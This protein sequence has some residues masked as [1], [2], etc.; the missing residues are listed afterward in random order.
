M[1]SAMVAPASSL[2]LQ[3]NAQTH[4]RVPLIINNI[5][6]HDNSDKNYYTLADSAEAQRLMQEEIHCEAAWAQKSFMGSVALIEENACLAT[7]QALQ[8][9]IPHTHREGAHAAVINRPFG[10]VLGIAP[11]NSP[12]ILAFRAVIAPL[13]AGNTVILKGSEL[14]PKTRF[15]VAN[16]FVEAGFPPGVVNFLLHRPQDAASVV[17]SLINNPAV[18]KINFTGSTKVGR[19]IAKAAGE[20]IKPVLLELGGKNCVLVLEDTDVQRAAEGVLEG[21][22][23]NLRRDPTISA[24]RL[25]IERQSQLFDQT[26]GDNNRT[27]ITI[28]EGITESM[29]ILSAESFGPIA[30]IRVVSDENEAISIVNSLNHGLFS[31]LW[32]KDMHR[33]WRLP[34]G[35]M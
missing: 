1:A 6:I 20:A 12:L 9:S 32:T 29:D 4:A 19:I 7:S 33:A 34:L 15:F 16:L 18:R 27:P 2:P 22:V 3:G 35:F 14:S 17:H 8:G 24:C 10:V 25:W 26:K 28:L 23:E 31:P 11:W 5:A 13:V 30:G 21:M